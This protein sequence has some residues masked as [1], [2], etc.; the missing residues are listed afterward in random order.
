[1]VNFVG[2]TNHYR[3]FFMYYRVYTF[4][5][6]EIILLHCYINYYTKYLI[7]CY[8]VTTFIEFND[9]SVIV[10]DSQNAP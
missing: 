10:Q 7:W 4:K 5:Y 3:I 8:G 1:M 6:F 9:Q 2:L